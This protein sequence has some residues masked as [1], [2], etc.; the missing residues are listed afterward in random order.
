MLHIFVL[1]KPRSSRFLLGRLAGL[2][3]RWAVYFHEI[4]AHPPPDLISL[5]LSITKE[6]VIVE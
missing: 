2:T 1:Q 4:H 6:G 3:L 5:S